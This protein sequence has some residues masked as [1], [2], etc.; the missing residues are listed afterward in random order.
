MIL[1]EF[2]PVGDEFGIVHPDEDKARQ[3]YLYTNRAVKLED[4]V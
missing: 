4:W 3:Q 2:N 1:K